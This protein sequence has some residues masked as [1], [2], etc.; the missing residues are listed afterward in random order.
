MI[1]K[2]ILLNEWMEYTSWIFTQILYA[3]CQNYN[4][5]DDYINILFYCTFVLYIQLHRLT[6]PLLSDGEAGP[7]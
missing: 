7:L 1:A 2:V 4:Y 5:H 3:Y 6:Y